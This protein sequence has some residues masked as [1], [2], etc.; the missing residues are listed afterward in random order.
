[1]SAVRIASSVARTINEVC[2]ENGSSSLVTI[3]E[4][5]DTSYAYYLDV[6]A[7]GRR[8]DV[9]WPISSQ[10]KS[11]AVPILT[12]NIAAFNISKTAGSNQTILVITDINDFVNVTTCGNGI[13]DN[14]EN[15]LTC[16]ADCV[17]SGSTPYCCGIGYAHEGI[18]AAGMGGCGGF[19]SP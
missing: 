3:P 9:F 7:S 11:I 1:V 6:Q 5:L 19:S 13:C 17:C 12:N 10:N 16:P 8:V 18:C 14:G 2:K 15:C 4:T